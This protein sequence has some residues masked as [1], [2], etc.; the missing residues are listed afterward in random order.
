MITIHAGIQYPL[1]K[2]QRRTNKAYF[3]ATKHHHPANHR[4][5]S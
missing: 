5:S 1:E 4:K 2:E 3:H